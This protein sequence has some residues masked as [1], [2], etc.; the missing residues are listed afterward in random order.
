MLENLNRNT[1][2]YK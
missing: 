1:C 2:R